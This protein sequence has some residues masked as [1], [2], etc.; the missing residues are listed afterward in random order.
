M[1]MVSSD[2][3]ERSR[4]INVK[5]PVSGNLVIGETPGQVILQRA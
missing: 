5:D 1:L 2:G 4:F 3:S